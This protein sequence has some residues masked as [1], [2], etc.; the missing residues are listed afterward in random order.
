MGAGLKNSQDGKEFA[1]LLLIKKFLQGP[2][3]KERS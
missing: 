2:G 3:E 1:I